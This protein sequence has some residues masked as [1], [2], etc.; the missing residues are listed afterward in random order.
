MIALLLLIFIPLFF[1]KLDWVTLSSW[2]EAWYGGIAR[3]IVRSGDWIHLVWN[4]VPFYDHPPL[5]FWLM[6][7]SYKIFGINEFATRFPSALLSVFSIVLLYVIGTH[8]SQ[9]KIVGFV[10]A[11]ILG[12]SV[13]Y[14]I[15]VRSGNLDA[16]FVF[17]Y[18]LTIYFSIK[19][20]KDMRWFPLVGVA[21]GCLILTKTL[22]GVSAI[23]LILFLVFSQ[24]LQMRKNF[25]FLLWGIISFSMVVLPWYLVQMKEYADFIT[26]H[27][28]RIG[29]RNKTLG[30]YTTINYELPLFYIHM[31]IRKWYYLWLTGLGYLILSLRFTKKYVLFLILWNI[32]VL[33]PFLTSEKTELWHLIPVYLPIALITSLGFYT[34]FEHGRALIPSV[35][36]TCAY[37]LFFFIIFVMQVKTFH[38]E[39]YPSSRYIPDDVDITRRLGKYPG[40]IYIDGD[41]R[42]LAVFYSGRNLEQVSR[43][44]DGKKT[45]RELLLS[46]EKNFAVAIENWA[47]DMLQSNKIP[48]ILL[49]K[50]SSYSIIT[51]V[52]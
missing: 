24:L 16:I 19:S 39:V 2:D 47:I 21:F 31:G 41:Y 36:M 40:N 44:P 18:L 10:A 51:A 17:F 15:R 30:S 20:S 3:E 26:Y 50:N 7:L 13:W 43:L 29:M 25:W 5:G 28:L 22:V 52:K 4:G 8:I 6:A 45:V 49:E 46:G 12:S 14:L 42:P 37:V 23:I 38:K 34:M 32:V 33:Y 11:L 27:F 35:L 48:F 1:Y 9:K